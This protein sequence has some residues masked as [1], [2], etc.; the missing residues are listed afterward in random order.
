[1]SNEAFYNIKW[2]PFLKL[3]ATYGY[4]GNVYN[5]S[6]YLTFLTTLTN[7]LTGLRYALLGNPP[8]PE[9]K[10]ERVKNIN[11]GIDFA[12]AGNRIEGTLELYKKQGLDLIQ[13]TPLAPSTGF[14]T[15]KGNAAS[16]M[17]NGIDLTLNTRNTVGEVKWQTNFLFSYLKD[18]ITFLDNKYTAANLVT[19]VSQLNYRTPPTTLFASVGRSLFGVYSYKWGGLDATNGNPQGYLNGNISTDYLAILN[20]A[21]PDNLIYH[22]SARPTIFGAIRNT[23][24][25]KN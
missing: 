5:A 21:T 8:N 25:F 3:R 23:I 4:N 12:I 9:L 13:N 19:A 11:L 14:S 15:F 18:E 20:S 1:M 7:N 16:T 24:S 17:T 10:W 22:G 6:A 2:L